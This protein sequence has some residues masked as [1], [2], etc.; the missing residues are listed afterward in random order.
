MRASPTAAGRPGGVTTSHGFAARCSWPS[1]THEVPGLAPPARLGFPFLTTACCWREQGKCACFLAWASPRAY[2]QSAKPVE[3]TVPQCQLLPSCRFFSPRLAISR[4][5]PLPRSQSVFF[6]RL[7][8]H[9]FSCSGFLWLGAIGRRPVRLGVFFV[10]MAFPWWNARFLL[11]TCRRCSILCFMAAL[12]ILVCVTL[13]T[14]YRLRIPHFFFFFCQC[15]CMC[16]RS[17]GI[18]SCLS[19]RTRLVCVD[20]SLCFALPWTGLSPESLP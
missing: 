10:L 18:C 2:S 17:A 13:P 5:P 8:T 6:S 15:L 20:F 9:S 16:G 4:R 11:E 3:L 14:V 1:S 7:L 12:S 19:R